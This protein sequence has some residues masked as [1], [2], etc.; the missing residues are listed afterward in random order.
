MLPIAKFLLKFLAAGLLHYSG[1]L[2]L[3][4]QFALRGRISCLLYHR[5]LPEDLIATSDSN[6]GL[7]V[8]SAT[9]E[10][11]MRFLKRW[12]P[13]SD[14]GVLDDQGNPSKISV[15]VT[16]DDGWQ[17]NFD[18]AA[19]IMR[20]HDIPGVIFLATDYIGTD[21]LFW[22][23]KLIKAVRRIWSAS[24]GEDPRLERIIQRKSRSRESRTARALI[25]EYVS[26]L[27]TRGEGEIRAALDVFGAAS[28]NI[29][30]ADEVD[31]FMTW[32]QARELL[33]S[34][35]IE[36]GSHT[37]SH[38]MMTQLDD[39]NIEEELSVSRQKLE[40]EL[41]REGILFAYPNGDRNERVERIL[42][43]SAY[44][45][46]FEVRPGFADP[47]REPVSLKRMMIHDGIAPNI[48]MFHCHLLGII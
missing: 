30:A 17:D 5:V 9:F 16:F 45:Y 29:V 43:G 15:L 33:A 23:E 7:I 20:A 38:R 24:G 47:V 44:R 13:P 48:P 8:S 37:A 46:A 25:S 10:K 19:P 27:K 22:Q 39:E 34:Q 4:G 31:R 28:R 6:R 14:S 21:N 11:Q 32:S 1:A 41:S 12:Y 3:Y 42:D 18:H 2:F 36:F 26:D 35:R 40:R